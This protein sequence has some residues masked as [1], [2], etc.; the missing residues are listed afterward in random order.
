MMVP[1]KMEYV[2]RVAELPTCQKMLAACALP[3]RTTRLPEAVVSAL[4][5]WKMKTEFALPPPSSVRTPV[6]PNEEV[7]LYRPAARVCPPRSPATIAGTVRPAAS[8]YAVVKSPWAVAAVRSAACIA[9]PTTVP[10][11]NPVTALPGLTPKFPLTIVGPV[12]VTVEPANAVK[13]PAEFRAT[14]N[15]AACR[16]T[17][18]ATQNTSRLSLFN[19]PRSGLRRHS[20][21][22]RVYTGI[23][24]TR[25]L[26]HFRT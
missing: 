20:R 23:G 15:W 19:V 8:L 5:I 7:D 9:P 16:Q 3:M 6:M 18:D 11:G 1:L 2:P 12:F 14:G 25:I 24:I 10:G 21:P 4:P 22:V 13:F 26:P 17:L